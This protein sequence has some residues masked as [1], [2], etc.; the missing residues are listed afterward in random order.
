MTEELARRVMKWYSV[1][2]RQ[3]P[4]RVGM[5]DEWVVALTAIL[6]RKTR[7][8]SVA[9]HYSRIVAA[10]SSPQRALELGVEG[11]E[12]LLRPLG[13][14]H[15][16]ARQIYALAENWDKGEKPGLGPYAL[17]LIDC[18][19]K[20]MLVPVV[21]V[22]TRRVVSRFF[23]VEEARVGELLADAVRA[24][25]TCEL[26][27]ALMDLAATVCKPRRPACD[28]CPLADLCKYARSAK[29]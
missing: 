19:L 24:A 23:G 6:L 17:S 26:N 14:H 15:T 16:R 13:L 20:G 18:L 27:L 25:G 1:N 12:E 22:N 10:I 4:W 2:K 9:K 7:A 8:E 21:D 11:I 5:R 28:R 29:H 3:F